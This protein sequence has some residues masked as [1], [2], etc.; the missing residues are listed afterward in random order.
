MSMVHHLNWRVRTVI[1][2]QIR[3][4]AGCLFLVAG[5]IA[6]TSAVAS[7][8]GT[9]GATAPVQ[10]GSTKTAKFDSFV[11]QVGINMSTA[12][13]EVRNQLSKGSRLVVDDCATHAPDHAHAHGPDHRHD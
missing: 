12:P 7:D 10:S 2:V 1:A 9:T 3:A 6:A 13:F 5:T 8:Q 4:V 11:R